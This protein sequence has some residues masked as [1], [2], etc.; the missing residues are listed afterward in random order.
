VPT[1]QAV[2]FGVST[3]AARI[4]A[5]LSMASLPTWRSGLLEGV[6]FGGAE[7]WV[8]ADKDLSNAK[9]K[10]ADLSNAKLQGA[11]LSGAQGRTP[12]QVRSVGR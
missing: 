11:V 10:G 12:F 9:I 4:Y 6:K 1:F 2:I 5:V 7:G 8:R 3:E